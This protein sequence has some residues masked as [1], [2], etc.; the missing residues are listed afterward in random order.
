MFR[1]SAPI[2]QKWI[3]VLRIDYALAVGIEHLL[4]ANPI[5]P[6][7]KMLRRS[8]FGLTPATLS[9]LFVDTSLQRSAKVEKCK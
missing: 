5:P 8:D 4:A 3:P 9:L 7:R 6:S 1:L 2:P